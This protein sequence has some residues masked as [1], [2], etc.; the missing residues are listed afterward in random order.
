MDQLILNRM[1]TQSNT[2]KKKIDEEQEFIKA[3]VNYH[4]MATDR[5]IKNYLL[6]VIK[7]D[8]EK[9]NNMVS[10]HNKIELILIQINLSL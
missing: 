9:H 3:M 2:L 1:K 5:G 10:L 6:S 4:T 8:V 7:A